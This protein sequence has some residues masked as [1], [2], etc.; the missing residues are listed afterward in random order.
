MQTFKNYSSC[1]LISPSCFWRLQDTGVQLEDAFGFLLF[2]KYDCN[3]ELGLL[4]KTIKFYN[5]FSRAHKLNQDMI[6]ILYVPVNNNLLQM[7]NLD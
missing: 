3:L 5:V 2:I 6:T 1:K 7:K 4:A